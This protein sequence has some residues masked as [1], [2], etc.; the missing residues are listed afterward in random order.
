MAKTGGDI[1]VETLIEWGVD[2]IFGIPGDGING[3]IEV[4]SAAPGQDQVR[5]GPSRGS[6]GVRGLRLC[7]VHRQARRLPRDLR[8]RR[9]PPAE[10]HLRRQA[11]QPAGARDHRRAASR[12]D[13]NLHPAGRRTR[14]IVHGCDRLFGAGHG[15]GACRERGRAG[16]PHRPRLS[17]A[18]ACDDP[19]RLPVAAGEGPARSATSRITCRTSW[20]AAASS[21]PRDAAARGRHSQRGRE[22]VHPRRPRRDRRD[23]KS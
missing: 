7:Q 11:R 20:R 15:P 14:Q 22:A 10:R 8:P 16:M 2:T 12:S 18:D 19:G 13:R 1:L 17:P 21:R 5:P 3:V 9:N 23:A 6:G 4:A